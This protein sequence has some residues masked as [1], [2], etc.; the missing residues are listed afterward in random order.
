MIGKH[1]C[2]FYRL[3]ILHQKRPLQTIAKIKTNDIDSI[4]L[5]AE[6]SDDSSL[7]QCTLKWQAFKVQILSKN[8]ETH[9]VGPNVWRYLRN[10][11]S[12]D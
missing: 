5:A 4:D 6:Q 2:K 9:S 8:I 12:H 11:I 1:F 3:I 10:V 7:L